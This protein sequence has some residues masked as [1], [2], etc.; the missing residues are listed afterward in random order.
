[1]FNKQTLTTHFST[2][3]YKSF[4]DGREDEKR[5]EHPT[6]STNEENVGKVKDIVHS[7]RRITTRETAEKVVIS[8]GSCEQIFTNGLGMKQV[9]VKF[10][11][12]LLVSAKAASQKH[13]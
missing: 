5:T 3:G 10:V 1:M 4:Q 9:V 12:K 13:R 6:I 8:Y 11:S 2:L 7:I